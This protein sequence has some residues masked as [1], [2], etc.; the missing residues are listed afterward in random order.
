MFLP[1]SM[2]SREVWICHVCFQP[3]LPNTHA[4]PFARSG[5]SAS[6]QASLRS[7]RSSF[8]GTPRRPGTAVEC[9]RFSHSAPADSQQPSETIWSKYVGE[10][11]L[12]FVGICGSRPPLDQQ[13]CFLTVYLPGAPLLHHQAMP[14]SERLA[15]TGP[16]IW[17]TDRTCRLNM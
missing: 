8:G 3:F 4:L 7:Q 6:R 13:F 12:L 16:G 2:G 9:G 14:R 11:L 5:T 1:D 10:P 15:Q 17:G